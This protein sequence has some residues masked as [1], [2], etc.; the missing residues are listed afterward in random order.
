MKH[1]KLFENKKDILGFFYYIDTEDFNNN[2][3]KIFDDY[4]SAQ[5]FY[6]IWIN[7]EKEANI[8]RKENREL[9]DDEILL[10]FEEAEEYARDNLYT[11]DINCTGIKNSGTYDLPEHFKMLK[12]TRKYNM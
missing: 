4:Q 2:Y 5:N 7:D 9:R 3:F 8:Q 11:L 10:T 1:L 6:I 12:D